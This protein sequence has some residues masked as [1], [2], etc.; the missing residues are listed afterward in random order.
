MGTDESSKGRA[1][2]G[3]IYNKLEKILVEVDTFTS[4]STLCLNSDDDPSGW[5]S[6]RS[7]PE[8]SAEDRSCEQHN[9]GVAL[10]SCKSPDD[11]P[12]HQKFEEQFEQEDGLKENENLYPFSFAD[13]DD[14]DSNLSSI[15]TLGVDEE[16]IL[17]DVESQFIKTLVSQISSAGDPLVFPQ[18]CVEKMGVVEEECNDDTLEISTDVSNMNPIATKIPEIPVQDN[19]ASMTSFNEVNLNDVCN[20]KSEDAQLDSKA[21]SAMEFQQD[22]SHVDDN[23]L[24]AVRVRTKKLRSFKRKILDALTSKR[25]REKEYEHLPIWFGDADMG[26]DLVTGG[27]SKQVEAMDSKSSQ[28]QESQDSQWELL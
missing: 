22:P 16:P 15:T 11:P 25:R 18:T 17:T 5:E 10:P 6:V 20:G 1:W 12:S 7:E 2:F 28:V 21:L 27:D 3:K 24:Y 14:W 23:A 26:S 19:V 9:G 8:E 4:Q 13:G